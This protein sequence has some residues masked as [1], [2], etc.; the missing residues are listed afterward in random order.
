M[1]K[2]SPLK[3]YVFCYTVRM[4]KSKSGF[5]IVELLIVIVVIGILAAITIV[6]YNGIQNRGYDSSVHSDM[7]ALAKQ[8]ELLK[9]DSS[10]G[11]YPYGNNSYTFNLKVNKAAY[12]INSSTPYNLLVC[13]PGAVNSSQYTILTTSKSGKRFTMNNGASIQEYTGGVSWNTAADA[14]CAA[15]RS[16]GWVGAAAGYNAGDTTSTG[17]W[18]S[19]VGGN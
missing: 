9:I 5:T 8:L 10:D 16:T 15:M 13:F 6:A 3:F 14:I 11:N 4:V 12:L 1:D 7:S 18:R 17:P 2:R 19:W